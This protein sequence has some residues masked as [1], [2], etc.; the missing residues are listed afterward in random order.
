LIAADFGLTPE[1][2]LAGVFCGG[3]TPPMRK[4][5]ECSRKM[6]DFLKRA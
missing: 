4:L 6:A 5:S 3:S 1:K 2:A